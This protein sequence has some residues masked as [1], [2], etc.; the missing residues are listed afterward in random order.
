MPKK[1]I[2]SFYKSLICINHK[3][4]TMSVKKGWKLIT[5]PNRL[6]RFWNKLSEV[7]ER[8]PETIPQ[9]KDFYNYEE[10]FITSLAKGHNDPTVLD[11]GCGPG[12]ILKLLSK[13]GM[14]KLYGID[15]SSKMI[16]ECRLV[17]PESVVLLQHDFRERLPFTDNFF[18]YVFITGNTLSSSVTEIDTI[19]RNVHRVLKENGTLVIGLYNSEFMTEEFVRNYYGKFPKVIAL[20]CFDKENHTVFVGDVY[21]HWMSEG[22]VKALFEDLDFDVKIEKK[23]IGFI[24]CAK[25]SNYKDM[26]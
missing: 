2:N 14:N 3:V 5:D 15:I 24:V 18:D 6:E 8:I 12:R 16:D 20:K 1:K 19:L 9:V 11:L 23:G 21:S 25:K 10:E 17:L 4:V 7:W 26:G 13:V 22:E